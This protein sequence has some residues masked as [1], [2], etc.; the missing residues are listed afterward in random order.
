[1]LHPCVGAYNN[2]TTFFS[3][4][5]K[6]IMTPLDPE[7]DDSRGQALGAGA[8]YELADNWRVSAR[9]WYVAIE[10]AARL[11]GLPSLDVDI[12]PRVFVIGPGKKF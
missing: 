4:E 10:A 5:T 12:D 6:G 3:E 8:D 7:L 9:L 11:T 2:Y 1:M